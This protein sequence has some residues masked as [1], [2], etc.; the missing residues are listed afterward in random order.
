MKEPSDQ[1]LADFQNHFAK[2][3]KAR[4][5]PEWIVESVLGPQKVAYDAVVARAREN[6]QYL[7]QARERHERRFQEAL[8]K[9][10]EAAK[11][12]TKKSPRPDAVYSRRLRAAL[13]AAVVTTL[14]LS[15][16]ANATDLNARAKLQRRLSDQ[17]SALN[18]VVRS[19]A[20][21][22]NS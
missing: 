2:L 21:G 20:A 9:A 18:E 1:L 17:I 5:L 4:R 12:A 6:Q 16:E 10:N 13:D 22:T 7:K 8:D 15:R 3:A 14:D 19:R 11:T